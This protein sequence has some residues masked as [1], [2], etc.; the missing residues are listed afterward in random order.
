MT[1]RALRSA[2]VVLDQERRD[3]AARVWFLRGSA[4][5][6]VV[7]VFAPTNLLEEERPCRIRWDF[8]VPSGRRFTDPPY[9]LLLETAKQLLSLIRIRSFPSGH[10][11]RAST[12]AKLFMHLRG[13][14]Q[15]MDAEGCSRFADLDSAALLRFQRSIAQR[16]GRIGATVAPTTV[17]EYLSLCSCICITFARR[18]ATDCLSIPVPAK[19][20]VNLRGCVAAIFITDLTRPTPS[21]CR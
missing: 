16:Q 19:R 7:W 9:A 20:P 4:W 1:A 3:E 13:L 8:I 21:R 10:T 6:D 12:V 2:N 15:W 11:H 5:D 18:S 17:Q 14:L